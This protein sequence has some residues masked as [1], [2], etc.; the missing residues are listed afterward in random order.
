MEAVTKASIEAS[1]LTTFLTQPIWVIKT[2]M[3]LNVNKKISEFQNLKKQSREI[4]RQHGAAG[5]LKGLQLSIFLSFSGVVQMYAYESAK[6]L[7]EK[8]NIP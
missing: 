1:I 3:L 6:I 8:L 7:Y 2:R 5:F 4:Y